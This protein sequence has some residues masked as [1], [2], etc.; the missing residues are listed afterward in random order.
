MTSNWK[1]RKLALLALL[2]GAA[3]QPCR[4]LTGES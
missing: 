4:R 2:K 3:K 1:R